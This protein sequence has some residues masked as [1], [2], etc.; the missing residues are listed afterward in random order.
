MADRCSFSGG[1]TA[2][3]QPPSC[4]C[5]RHLEQVWGG[6]RRDM[7]A[8]RRGSPG[9]TLEVGPGP[10]IAGE[11]VDRIL[12]LCVRCRL[13]LAEATEEERAAGEHAWCARRG[14]E[15]GT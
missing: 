3:A 7:S 8:D 2:D 10:G 12:G 14:R 13:S 1:C 6:R 9:V 5:A 15:R 4:L 11:A